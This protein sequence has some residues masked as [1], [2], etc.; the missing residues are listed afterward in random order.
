MGIYEPIEGPEETAHL[1]AVRIDLYKLI[2]G[3]GLAASMSEAGRLIKDGA[4]SID[5]LK[6]EDRYADLLRHKWKS[7]ELSVRVGKRC[8]KVILD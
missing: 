6:E 5:G 4:L 8:K 3:A 7:L 2:V 1:E